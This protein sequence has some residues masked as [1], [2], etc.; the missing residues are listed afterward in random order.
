M[1][2]GRRVL[3]GGRG[4]GDDVRME[5]VNEENGSEGGRGLMGTACAG[6]GMQGRMGWRVTRYAR[7]TWDQGGSAGREL[8]R[9]GDSRRRGTQ[10]CLLEALGGPREASAVCGFTESWARLRR[11]AGGDT[12]PSVGRV[13]HSFLPRQ[14]PSGLRAL[15]SWTPGLSL[16]KVAT[17]VCKN[18]FYG[19]MKKLLV[20]V[21]L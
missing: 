12:P 10:R 19:K 20:L 21:G 15:Q 8:E 7:G 9:A 4:V 1:G 13:T 14:R 2:S 5:G 6:R 3:G 17:N 11:G 18:H 16:H